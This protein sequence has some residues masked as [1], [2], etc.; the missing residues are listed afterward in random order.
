M[1][2]RGAESAAVFLDRDGVIIHN[3]AGYVRSW[4]DVR[5]YPYAAQALRLLAASPF[6]VVVVSNQSAVGRGLMSA[7]T[8]ETIHQR[9]SQLIA[10]HGGRIDGFFVCPHAPW[11]GCACRKPEPGL[12][13]QAAEALHLD[14]QRSYLVGDAISDIQ[15]GQRADLLA[16]IL[17]LSGRG[18][19]Q[20]HLAAARKIEPF[21]V[22]RTLLQATKSILAGAYDRQ[23]WLQTD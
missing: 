15:A 20:V 11:E 8:L 1:S 4:Q 21:P 12:L 9:L 17:V 14:L 23:A 3:R 16:S 7:E 10:N 6:K 5:L 19:K 18:K 13:F 22:E 2:P